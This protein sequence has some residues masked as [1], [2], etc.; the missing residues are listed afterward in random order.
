MFIVFSLFFKGTLTL[1]RNI[2]TTKEAPSVAS[3]LLPAEQAAGRRRRLAR[4]T[5]PELGTL[6]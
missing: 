6:T 1:P 5:Y 2:K 3:T 4:V